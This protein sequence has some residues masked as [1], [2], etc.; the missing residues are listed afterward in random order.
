VFSELAPG[1]RCV[2]PA[3][4]ATAFELSRVHSQSYV[5]ELT[6]RLT[7]GHGHL[8]PDTYFC[9]QT[10]E[11]AWL[12][13]GGCIDL[14]HTLLRGEA[15]TGIALLRPPG[16][17]AVP[18]R[19]MGFCLLNNVA[20]AARAALDSGLSRVAIVDWDVHHGNGTQDAFYEDPR[21]LFISLHQF[22][23]YPGTGAPNHTGRN[24]GA[25][26]TANVAL[27][28]DSDSVVYGT[29]FREV[30][31]PLLSA[32]APEL[33]LVSAGFDAHAR[34]PLASM[35]LESISYAALASSLLD[36]AEQLG[37][38]RVGFVLEG[39]Y[40]LVALEESL[41]WVTRAALGE[42]IE[43]PDG[44]MAPLARLAIDATR[45]ALAPHW[46]GIATPSVASS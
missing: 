30:V 16:H 31:T 37:H 26:F 14:V 28:G 25:G 44:T 11:A 18:D 38:G 4:E 45:A 43:L 5:D 17:H 9:P 35:Q 20:L 33:I 2:V 36:V 42:R 22:P 21:V 23:F 34:D 3:R 6:Q 32:Y 19:S 29:A 24:A 39:G 12:A 1:A 8:D 13:A 10:R 46:P 27:P 40:D 41:A 15:R 7:E